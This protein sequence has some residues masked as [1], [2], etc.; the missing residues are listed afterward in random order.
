[1]LLG[2]TKLARRRI[3]PALAAPDSHGTT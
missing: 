2:E 1:L 3:P